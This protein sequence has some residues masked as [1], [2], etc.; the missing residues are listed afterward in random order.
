MIVYKNISNHN[1]RN[2]FA[3][4]TTIAA[5]AV[6][7]ISSLELLRQPKADVACYGL[8][9]TIDTV[10]DFQIF[11]LVRPKNPSYDFEVIVI[12]LTF[13]LEV[14]IVS[15]QPTRTDELMKVSSH[16]F[17][18]SSM[19]FQNTPNIWKKLVSVDACILLIGQI[20]NIRDL[21]FNNSFIAIHVYD[22]T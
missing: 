16:R 7:E 19:V 9:Y 8:Q 13:R 18:D 17:Q 10:F 12:G 21:R 4:D 5:W 11:W 15:P 1:G 2:Q 20:E 3:I 22:K 6:D 14:E